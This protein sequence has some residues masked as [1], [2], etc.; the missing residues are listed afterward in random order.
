MTDID[1]S[2][3]SFKDIAD[4]IIERDGFIAEDI[5]DAVAVLNDEYGYF[6]YEKDPVTET[7]EN[8][9][10]EFREE[11]ERL[12]DLYRLKNISELHRELESLFYERLGRIS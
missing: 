5:D 12:F 4:E 10:Q 8:M 3:V 7:A 6:I 1:L 9:D 2:E 11:L